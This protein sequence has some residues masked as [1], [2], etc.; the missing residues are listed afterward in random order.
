MRRKPNSSCR[1]CSSR[2]DSW[3][4]VRKMRLDSLLL[5]R[6]IV[7]SVDKA[8]AVIGAGRVEVDGVLT[9][10]AGSMFSPDCSIRLIEKQPYVGRGGEKLAAGLDFFRVDPSGL[11]CVDVGC[12]TGGFTDCLLQ[13]GARRVYCVDVGYG[14]LDWRLRQDKR[15]VVLERTNARYL[16]REQIPEPVDLAVID[17]SFISLGLLLA[18][19]SR[20][21][22]GRISIMALIK[23]QFELPRHKVAKGGVVRESVLHEETIALVRGHVLETGLVC[24]G[25]APSPIKGAKGNREFLMYIVS[26]DEN[27]LC[28]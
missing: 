23:P 21:F 3:P 26:P 11:V 16:T 4:I 6:G 13:N 1:T 24:E 22:A 27:K 10:K 2:E 8:R 19:V 25:V 18:P 14:V 12:S 5:E 20:L 9:D 17:A 7:E 15:V 28:T